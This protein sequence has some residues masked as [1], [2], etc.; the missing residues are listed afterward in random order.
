MS[1]TPAPDSPFNWPAHIGLMVLTKQELHAAD[2]SDFFPWDLP[3]VAAT[4][5]KLAA[6]E[7]RLGF[8]LDP[9]HRA[10][11]S[12]AD[13]WRGFLAGADLLSSEELGGAEAQA[14]LDTVNSEWPDEMFEEAGL[15]QGALFAIAADPGI[16]LAFVMQHADG[17]AQP[18]VT[19]LYN[20]FGEQYATFEEFFTAMIADNLEN[21]EDARRYAIEDGFA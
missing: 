21:I 2:A 14:E 10:F 18:H 19:W 16:G 20:G 17:V 8:T 12:Q 6:T 15:H 3:A 7:T 9:G 5:E 13:G 4:E 1:E 11:L